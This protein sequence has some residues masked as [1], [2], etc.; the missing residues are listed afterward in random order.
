MVES[1]ELHSILPSR[2]GGRQGMRGCLCTHGDPQS[3]QGQRQAI[4]E[5][6]KWCLT[7]PHA[8]CASLYCTTTITSLACV[9]ADMTVARMQRPLQTRNTRHGGLEC[10]TVYVLVFCGVLQGSSATPTMTTCDDLTCSC[11]GCGS[12][13]ISDDDVMVM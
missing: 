8:S 12:L 10:D 6:F 3:T 5:T 9:A 13:S 7:T 1:E 2:G 4:H 11:E